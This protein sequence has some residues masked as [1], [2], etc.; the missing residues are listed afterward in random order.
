MSGRTG[1]ATARKLPPARQLSPE[2]P[3]PVKTVTTTHIDADDDIEN[4][5]PIESKDESS[6]VQ[7][8]EFQTDLN[9]MAILLA[10]G[11]PLLTNFE[12]KYLLDL[13]VKP[14]S[15]DLE[16]ILQEKISLILQ[17]N[18]GAQ[19]SSF[20]FNSSWVLRLSSETFSNLNQPYQ[21]FGILRENSSKKIRSQQFHSRL[22]TLAIANI[23]QRTFQKLLLRHR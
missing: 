11:Q 10:N 13:L 23:S 19:S 20:H 22:Q 12:E 14:T 15:K 6:P 18:Y 3:S 1:K 7:S 5:M 17:T 21:C 8:P 9:P 2:I 16:S 4:Q